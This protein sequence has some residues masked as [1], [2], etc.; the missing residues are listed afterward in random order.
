MGR[1]MDVFYRNIA[2]DERMGEWPSGSCD[3]DFGFYVS[4]LPDPPYLFVHPNE[5]PYSENHL[6]TSMTKTHPLI[7]TSTLGNSVR[8]GTSQLRP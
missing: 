8:E 3:L 5:I 1:F 7:G 6:V 4:V 2:P